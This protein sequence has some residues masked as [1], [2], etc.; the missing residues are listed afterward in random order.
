MVGLRSIIRNISTA[1]DR[2]VLKSASISIACRKRKGGDRNLKERLKK[3]VN[4]DE[5]DT[6]G[7]IE[8]LSD[9]LSTKDDG[10]KDA[11]KLFISKIAGR[12]NREFGAVPKAETKAS[13]QLRETNKGV[14]FDLTIRNQGLKDMQI[15]V[16]VF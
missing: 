3:E 8:H 13:E 15:V 2:E 10:E 1:D 7:I 11:E 16:I 6:D 4:S 12:L 9:V 5:R 14:G